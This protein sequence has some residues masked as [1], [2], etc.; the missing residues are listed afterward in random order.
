[1]TES[2]REYLDFLGLDIRKTNQTLREAN[3]QLINREVGISYGLS[4]KEMDEAVK[5]AEREGME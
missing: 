4:E 2:Q 1:M 3:E 5:V